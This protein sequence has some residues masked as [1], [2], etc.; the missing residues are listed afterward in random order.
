MQGS[1]HVPQAMT[2]RRNEA[3]VELEILYPLLTQPGSLAIP[4][5]AV[6]PKQYLPPTQLDKSAGRTSGYFPDFSIWLIGYPVAVV[7]A[8]DPS[9]TSETGFRERSSSEFTIPYRAQSQRGYAT[10]AEKTRA[11][12][13]LL[14]FLKLDLARREKNP[15]FD[16]STSGAVYVLNAME[17]TVRRHYKLDEKLQSDKNQLDL[18]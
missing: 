15:F 2:T 11:I 6:K 8:K 5:D 13:A 1:G 17:R 9:V 14:T 7:E 12:A 16:A 4:M 10:L 3:A 18:I